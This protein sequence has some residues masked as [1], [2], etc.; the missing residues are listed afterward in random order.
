[1]V[2]PARESVPPEFFVRGRERIEARRGRREG[3]DLQGSDGLLGHECPPF[4]TQSEGGSRGLIHGMY[5]GQAG[6]LCPGTSRP[7]PGGQP[8][9]QAAERN[10]LL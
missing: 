7:M 5:Q 3:V 1:M 2:G 10:Y 6:V 8:L 9:R 4:V